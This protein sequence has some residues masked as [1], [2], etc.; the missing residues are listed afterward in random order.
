MAN[1]VFTAE[2]DASRGSSYGGFISG[3][4]EQLVRHAGATRHLD[5]V[6]LPVQEDDPCDAR[7]I[8]VSL[9]CRCSS[10]GSGDSESVVLL[11]V[12]ADNLYIRGYRSQDGRWWEFRGGAVIDGSTQ[13][14]F[15]DSY[16]QM[17]KTA[18]V[19]LEEVTLGKEE[20]EKAVRQLAAAENSNAGSQQ[21]TARSL[22]TIS[23][24][25][26]EAIRF[27][28]IAGVLGYMMCNTSRRCVLP[29]HMVK[30]VKSWGS[31]SVHWLGA[32]LYGQTFPPLQTDGGSLLQHGGIP[33]HLLAPATIVCQDHAMRALGVVLNLMREL[34]DKHRDALAAHWRAVRAMARRLDRE[35]D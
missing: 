30:Q 15:G 4:R 24:M 11:Q 17:G 21:E 8:D 32:T 5:L 25:I 19:E 18:G 16:G 1:P 29:A 14:S 6:V 23:V 9:R 10:S 28:S 3:V 13:L 35:R 27:R 34:Q 22:M 20:L 26:C 7:W 2:L 33:Q 31:L 12:R